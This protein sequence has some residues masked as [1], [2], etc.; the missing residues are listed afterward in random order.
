MD[1]KGFE[2]KFVCTIC[3]LGWR[4]QLMADTCRSS[5]DVVYIPLLRSDLGRLL[6]FIITGEEE[7]LTP[8][9]VKTLRYYM[10]AGKKEDVVSGLF[11]DN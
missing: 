10:R 4:N 2:G 3:G 5:H 8:S 9:L 7:L 6:Q 11:E 1:N